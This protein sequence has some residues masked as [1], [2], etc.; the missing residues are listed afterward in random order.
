M[1]PGVL[2]AW[3]ASVLATAFAYLLHLA[4]CFQTM[5]LGYEV[6]D[7]RKIEREWKEQLTL[8]QLEEATL[9]Q[10]DRVEMIARGTLGMEVPPPERVIMVGSSAP[11]ARGSGRVR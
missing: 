9:R 6:A 7:A 11:G 8:L 4:I 2:L 10:V 5:E 3:W 1:K